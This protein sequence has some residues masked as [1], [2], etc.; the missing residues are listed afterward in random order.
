MSV[1][2]DVSKVVKKLGNECYHQ[3]K[4]SRMIV[5]EITLGRLRSVVKESKFCLNSGRSKKSR[6]L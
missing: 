5:E 1:L 2:L 4:G 3:T 6:S